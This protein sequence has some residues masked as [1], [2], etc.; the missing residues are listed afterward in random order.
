[1]DRYRREL[2]VFAA[3]AVLLLI[4]AMRDVLAVLRGGHIGFYDPGQLRALIVS[5]AP[6]L[7]AAVGMTLVILARQIDIS[8]GSQFCICGVV[9]GLLAK[10]G[11]PMPLVA[12][13]AVLTGAGMGAANGAL[14]A[15]LGLPSIVVTL[16]TYAMFRE[17]LRW[18]REGAFVHDLPTGFQWF[19]SGQRAGQ[20]LVVGIARA[21]LLAFAWGLRHLSIGRDVYATGSDWEAARL[22][23]LRPRRVVFGVFVVMGALVGLAALLNAVRFPD[24]DPN[25]GTGKELQ[26]IAAVVVGG[27]A[28]SGGRGT[29]AGSLIGVAL[30]GT[31]G[32]ALSFLHTQPQ[33]EKAFQGAIILAAVATDSLAWRRK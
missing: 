9:A 14:V 17:S 19:G 10:A 23:G 30:L 4:L 16:A 21:V 24:V 2:S 29:L 6:L 15:G 26:A 1:M 11:L 20:W 25:A 3:Y 13:A 5:N 22:A 18:A 12:L 28:I 31:I 33:W 27:V 7:L 8:I 32:P